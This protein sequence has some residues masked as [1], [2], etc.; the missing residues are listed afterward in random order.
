M[1]E[2]LM[3]VLGV[4]TLYGAAS[5]LLAALMLGGY[6]WY[7]WGMDGDKVMRMIAVAQGFDVDKMEDGIKN[8]VLEEQMSITRDEIINARAMQDRNRELQG[9]AADEM[10]AQIESESARIEQMKKDI[11]EK[12]T[13]FDEQQKKLKETAESEGLADLTAYLE[14]A[15]PELAKFYILDMI[16][17]AE[18][19]RLILVLR[20][21][22][23]KKL[24]NIINVFEADEEKAD[25]ARVLRKIGN[26]EPEANLAAELQQINEGN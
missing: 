11:E 17:K 14:M 2:K 22:Q 8:A 15:D 18:Y 4:A 26:G 25:M 1:I 23:P 20:G 13:A 10:L 16:E 21:M 9:K 6:I 7:A 12:Q 24:K 3:R 5:L 19:D